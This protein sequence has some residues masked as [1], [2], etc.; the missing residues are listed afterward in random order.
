ML[1][2]VAACEFDLGIVGNSAP[3]KS[4]AHTLRYGGTLA[5]I[6][7]HMPRNFH[8]SF[9]SPCEIYGHHVRNKFGDIRSPWPA[10]PLGRARL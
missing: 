7:I 10:A 1:L 2:Q 3:D 4:R 6:G 9:T 8:P 5:L